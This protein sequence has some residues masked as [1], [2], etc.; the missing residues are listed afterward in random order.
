M[1]EMKD[2]DLRPEMKEELEYVF[3]PEEDFYLNE[4]GAPVF[5]LQPGI[6]DESDVLTTFPFTIE[7]ILDEM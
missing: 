6:V 1:K 7:E 2:A 4:D 3:F 5:Y